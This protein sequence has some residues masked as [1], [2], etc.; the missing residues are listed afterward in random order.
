MKLFIY[1]ALV[2]AFVSAAS[3]DVILKPGFPEGRIINGQDAKK[4]EAPFIVSLQQRHKHFCGGCIINKH[5]VMTAGHCLFYKSFEIVAGLHQRSNESD[6]Q[7]RKVRST[8]VQFIHEKYGGNVGPFD[9][10]LI[11]ISKPFNLNALARD[12]SA[13]VAKINLP[14]GK[15]EETG[16]GKL[17]GW[18]ID[19]SGASPD[20]LQKLTVNIISYFDC[21]QHMLK[22][23]PL[24]PS[25]ICTYNPGTTDGACNGDSGGPLVRNTPDGPEVV[26]CVS[27]GVTPCSSSS[28]A[29]VFTGISW[30]KNWILGTMNNNTVVN[31]PN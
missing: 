12:G 2:V 30:N 4:G 1:L 17:Y 10:G 19:N 27:W 9:I 15:Y 20:T 23:S 25:N 13:A 22:P 11:Y 5:W 3:L 6:V 14:S 31:T 16:E 18:G 26:G 24:H 21:I 8:A 28:Y 7:I 29:T